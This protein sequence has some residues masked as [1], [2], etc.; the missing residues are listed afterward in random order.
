M[1]QTA[2][3]TLDEAIKWAR[4]WQESAELAIPA[5][6]V[7]ALVDG[8]I[9]LKARNQTQSDS[10]MEFQEEQKALIDALRSVPLLVEAAKGILNV[11]TWR[12]KKG[13]Q[14]ALRDGINEL[15]A[16]VEGVPDVAGML[17]ELNSRESQS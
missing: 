17:L 14:S 13:Y 10:I 11:H 2:E 6:I 5:E 16:A 15:R 4:E 9:E 3:L 8:A 12:G 1:A 7:T